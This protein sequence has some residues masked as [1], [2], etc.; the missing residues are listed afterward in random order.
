MKISTKLLA[1]SALFALTFFFI[2]CFRTVPESQLW[3]G[4]RLLYV[5]SEKLSEQNICSILEKNGCKNVV[6][7]VN[8]K[9]PV[10]SEFAPIQVQP[11]NSYIYRKNG[12]FRDSSSTYLVFYVPEKSASA[13]ENAVSEIN[14]YSG[15]FASCDG[16]TVFPW[17]CPFL[18]FIFFAVLFYFSK[19]KFKFLIV[20]LLL[21]VLSV[22]R[23][24]YTV[25]GAIF[26]SLFA[27]FLL[28]KIY[29]RDGFF[30]DSKNAVFIVPLIV[31]SFIALAFSSVF[32]S[33][34]FAV[35]FAGGWLGLKVFE[36]FYSFFCKKNGNLQFDFVYIKK[37]SDVK[38]V[39]Q[40]NSFLLGIVFVF[41]AFLFA[42]SSI[43]S[44]ISQVSSS[45]QRPF[46]PAPLSS[47][48]KIS[49]EAETLPNLEDFVD[50]SWFT[51]SFPFKKLTSS[52]G[53]IQNSFGESVVIPDFFM[54][55]D[56][57]SG[58]ETIFSS[59]NKVLTYD[60]SFVHSIY[61]K[62]DKSDYPALEKVLLL[63]GKNT[64][65]GYTKSAGTSSEKA[66]PL[67]L[68]FF[69]FIPLILFLYYFVGTKKNEA[70]L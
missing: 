48:S 56:S 61:D 12:F 22:T 42:F 10:Y 3:K 19:Q 41:I 1:S 65:Y 36:E 5:K 64:S 8:Q 67:V 55:K 45:E 11:K 20:S 43:F 35:S 60:S 40:S 69:A 24:L 49:K 7:R 37:S 34:L 18:A 51:L 39:T 17:I 66:V 6:S 63:Q 21:L 44:G 2:I 47:N 46:L 14:G 50:W 57:S 30:K 25:C 33:F 32:S 13:L 26:L 31:F 27:N 38:T 28:V 4:W 16:G 15:T 59:Q 62:I 54:E 70:N 9:S 52:S 58:K 29:G 68:S 53:E 23:P